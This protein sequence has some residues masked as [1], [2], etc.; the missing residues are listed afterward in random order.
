MVRDWEVG[1]VSPDYQKKI[2]HPRLSI[3]IPHFNNGDTI[4]HC[5]NSIRMSRFQGYEI[6]VVDDAS[7]DNSPD[8]L[9]GMDVR[10]IRLHKNCGPAKAGI[11]WQRQ[12]G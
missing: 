7:I 6:I 8:I 5:I 9:A 1:D 2:S 4:A 12:Q 10:L 3:I 11:L